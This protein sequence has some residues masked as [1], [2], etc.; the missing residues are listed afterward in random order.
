MV[1]LANLN[2]IAFPVELLM[3][4]WI[5]DSRNLEYQKPMLNSYDDARLKY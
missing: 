4:K 3:P 2:P 1:E 5:A